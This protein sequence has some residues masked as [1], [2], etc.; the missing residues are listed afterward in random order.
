MAPQA[1]DEHRND[2]DDSAH[3]PIPWH[4]KLLVVALVIY[5]GFRAWQ[6]IELLL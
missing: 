4:L 5:L 6:G 2:V 1:G 3:A